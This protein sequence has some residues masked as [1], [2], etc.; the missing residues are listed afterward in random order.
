MSWVMGWVFLASVLIV[1]ATGALV[2][3]RRSRR[4]QGQQEQHSGFPWFWAVFP[5]AV[6]GLVSTLGMILGLTQS[7]IYTSFEDPVGLSMPYPVT[8]GFP[9]E[10]FLSTEQFRQVFGP[11]PYAVHIWFF[12]VLGVVFTIA[13][14]VAV[15]KG[16]M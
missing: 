15:R 1:A 14:V 3:P 9:V 16:R 6:L 12:P 2:I 4:R 11:L 5:P 10:E 8:G 13:S 7:T